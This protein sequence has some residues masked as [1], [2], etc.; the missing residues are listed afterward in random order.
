MIN[1]NWEGGDIKMRTKKI[2]FSAVGLGLIILAGGFLVKQA[3]ADQ[4][5]SYRRGGIV[6]QLTERFNLDQEEVDETVEQF[7]Q[8]HQAEMHLHH[9]ERWQKAVNDGAITEDQKQM[10]INKHEEMYQNRGQHRNEMLTWM[11]ENGI[12]FNVLREYGCGAQMGS[13]GCGGFNCGMRDK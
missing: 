1:F 2:I 8:E 9:E 5:Y 3:K 6:E 11:E 7:H 4:V 10:L 12:D 13:R